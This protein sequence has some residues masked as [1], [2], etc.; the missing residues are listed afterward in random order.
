MVVTCLF[1]FISAAPISVHDAVHHVYEPAPVYHAT[2][3]VH[4]TPVVHA[5]ATPVYKHVEVEAYDPNPEYH[6]S[7]G[8]ND[9]HT[10]DNHHAEESLQNGVV[11]GSYSL[12]EEDG[13]IRKVT[14][15]ADKEHGFNAVIEKS[16]PTKV[17]HAP[18]KLVAAA[19]IKYVAA[20][21][22]VKYVASATP[23]YHAP[24]YH[25]PEPIYHAP[26]H[27]NYVAPASIYHTA[28]AKIV[29]APAYHAP[30]L[31]SGYGDYHSFH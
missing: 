19:P 12:E 20:A 26:A 3:I 30:L 25:A 13:S 14:Y 8:V 18:V 15:T 7:Y 23:V 4:H 28:P 31:S 16:A 27:V 5:V 21:A 1:A 9:P 10:G 11:H 6:Y 29:A 22:P 24:V 2:P 17:V